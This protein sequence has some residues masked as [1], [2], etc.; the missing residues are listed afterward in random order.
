MGKPNLEISCADRQPMTRDPQFTLVKARKSRP[1]GE[2]ADD[3]FDVRLG[4]R[5]S[6]SL[7]SKA[8]ASREVRPDNQR[9]VG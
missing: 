1:E 8:Y 7:T 9:R 6:P 2:W 3:D 4:S 5:Y